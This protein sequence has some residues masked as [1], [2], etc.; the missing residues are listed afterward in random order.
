M[1]RALEFKFASTIMGV[2]AW[3]SS[4][5]DVLEE[6]LQVSGLVAQELDLVG[7]LLLLYLATLIVPLSD[8]FDF[9]LQLDHLV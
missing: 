4:G 3:C 2:I 1:K 9:A 8:G 5:L 6:S 7:T